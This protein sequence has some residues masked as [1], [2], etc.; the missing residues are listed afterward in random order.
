MATKAPRRKTE[1]RVL[2][3]STVKVGVPRGKGRA[4]ECGHPD[5]RHEA[6]GMCGPCY[7][8]WLYDRDPA[9]AVAKSRAANLVSQFGITQDEYDCMYAA[10]RGLC[11]I[12]GRI[13]KS[14]R[15]LAVDHSH[16]TGKVRGLLC[17]KCNNG[18]GNFD[19]DPLLLAQATVYLATRG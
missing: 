8:R 10:Q 15:R 3:S 1:L 2:G 17:A 14:G 4:T 11:L 12:C 19:D 18:L 16:A 9:A 7:S 13:C 6:R 5:R